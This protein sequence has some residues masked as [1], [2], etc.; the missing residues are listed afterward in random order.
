[1]RKGAVRPHRAVFDDSSQ[2]NAQ[3]QGSCIYT[4]HDR[5]RSQDERKKPHSPLLQTERQ[6]TL[7]QEE[8]VG[9]LDDAEPLEEYDR[10]RIRGSSLLYNPL[11]IIS[12]VFNNHVIIVNYHF[13]R[14]D[15]RDLPLIQRMGQIDNMVSEPQ[16]KFI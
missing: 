2:V 9:R 6:P 14:D 3:Y 15:K 1:M 10:D 8:R 16:I 4:R 11:I 13:L 7:L 12:Y 5:R